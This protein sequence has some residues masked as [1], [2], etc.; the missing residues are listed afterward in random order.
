MSSD[1][2]KLEPKAWITPL[3]WGS[4]V[5][6]HKPVTPAS[7]DEDMGE[8]YCHPL[9]GGDQIAKLS[10]KIRKLEADVRHWRQAQKDMEY[11]ADR[12]QERVDTLL[13]PIL[14]GNKP[15]LE[16]VARDSGG[17]LIPFN[18]STAIAMTEYQLSAF[19]QKCIEAKDKCQTCNGHGIVGGPTYYEP[20]EGGVNCPDCMPKNNKG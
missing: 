11:V 10:E 5:T 3:R 2:E 6:L 7:W 16:D 1:K 4:Q 12:L 15:S 20:G 18:G 14:Q 9:Y 8:W 19:L 17:C 13:K